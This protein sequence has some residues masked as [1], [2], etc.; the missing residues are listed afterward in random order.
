M[1]PEVQKS[2]LTRIVE[3][4]CIRSI[5]IDYEVMGRYTEFATTIL[6]A[7]MSSDH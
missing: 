1:D 2:L 7:S 3:Y 6:I 5:V 4:P